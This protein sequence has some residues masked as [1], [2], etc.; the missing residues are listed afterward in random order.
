M[1]QVRGKIGGERH[2]PNLPAFAFIVKVKMKN[3]LKAMFQR[4]T[5]STPVEDAPI[6][7]ETQLLEPL[8][9]KILR[10]KDWFYSEGHNGP[11][12]LWTLSK[13]DTSNQRPYTTGMRIQLFMKIKEGTGKTAKQFIMDNATTLKET[14]SKIIRTWIGE[15]QGI[16]SRIGLEVEEGS[17]HIIYSLFWTTDMAVVS[18]AGTTKE[19]WDT[20]ASTFEK[21]SAFELIDMT[22]FEKIEDA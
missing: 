18:T 17:Y 13:E 2:P 8:G 20:Y 22:R 4:V 15:K 11:V 10:P 12:Y 9:G 3:P 7:F 14:A 19:L 6:G 21:M 1:G 16:F 5:A